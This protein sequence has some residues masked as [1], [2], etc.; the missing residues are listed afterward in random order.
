[1]S[2]TADEASTKPMI[3]EWVSASI[4]YTSDAGI[5][6]RIVPKSFLSVEIDSIIKTICF[7]GIRTGLQ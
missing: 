5:I 6:A 4:F 1:M 7:K 3:K 2:Q